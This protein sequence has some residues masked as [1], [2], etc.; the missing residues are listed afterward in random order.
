MIVSHKLNSR[1]AGLR[2][3]LKTFFAMHSSVSKNNFVP[4]MGYLDYIVDPEDG[5]SKQA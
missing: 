5:F 2:Y 3:S 1:S 4:F